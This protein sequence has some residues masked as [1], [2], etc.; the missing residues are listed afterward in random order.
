[1]AELNEA[2]DMDRASQVV[3]RILE[4]V[5]KLTPSNK[6][7][8]LVYLVDYTYFQHYGETL[9]GL[10]YQWDH[11]GPNALDHAI[12]GHADSLTREKLLERKSGFNSR[13]SQMHLYRLAE[14]IVP[15]RLSDE[16]EMVISDI[17]AQYGML[18]V[19][20][21]TDVSKKT[22]PFANAE[23]YDRLEM[24]HSIPSM[25]ALE[26]NWDGHLAELNQQGTVS[27]E[28]LLEEHGLA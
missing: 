24:E 19:Q 14:S 25:S 10:E 9:S 2:H 12:V 13:G 7:V 23:Q 17:V 20:A 26:S 22:A 11:Y 27:L 8:K 4:Q 6:V 18:S 1:M 21:I 15:P 16:G 5:G 3:L 28:E